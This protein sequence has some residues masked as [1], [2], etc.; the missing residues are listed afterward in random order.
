MARG[1]PGHWDC[2]VVLLYKRLYNRRIEKEILKFLRISL[3]YFVKN[4][5]IVQK[6][7]VTEKTV[8]L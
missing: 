7:N 2:N 6:D 5:Q 3:F 8:Y 4:Q 1:L